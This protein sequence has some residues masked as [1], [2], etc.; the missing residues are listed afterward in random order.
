MAFL[1][2]RQENETKLNFKLCRKIFFSLINHS[3]KQM[4]SH[5]DKL[6]SQDLPRPEMCH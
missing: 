2:V 1:L 5:Y 3:A 6:L 4:V